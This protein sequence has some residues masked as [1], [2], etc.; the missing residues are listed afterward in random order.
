M[1]GRTACIPSHPGNSGALLPHH[2]SP[3]QHNQLTLRIYPS[4]TTYIAGEKVSGLLELDVLI[5][6]NKLSLG[7]LGI[8]FTGLEGKLWLLPFIFNFGNRV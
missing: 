3:K 8:E 2:P 6:N 5:G 7:E 1:A 4:K